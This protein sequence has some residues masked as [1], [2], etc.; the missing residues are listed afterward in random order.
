MK[1]V[2]LTQPL[3][4]LMASCATLPPTGQLRGS[5]A[6]LFSTSEQL[7]REK[8]IKRQRF[9]KKQ[10]YRY[11]NLKWQTGLHWSLFSRQ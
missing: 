10:A 7:P 5:M 4:V 3:D 9:L 11:S 6:M 1:Y 8:T 2:A